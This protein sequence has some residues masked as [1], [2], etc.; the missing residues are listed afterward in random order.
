M[1]LWAGR[2]SKEVDEEVLEYTQTI[3]IDHKLIQSD[4]WCSLAHVIMLYHQN[5]LKKEE[6]VQ[7]LNCLKSLLNSAQNG[8]MDLEKK[9]ED[10][11]LNIEQKVIE[12]T[13]L[14]LGGRMHTARSRNDQVVTD[15]RIYLRNSI[16][17]VQERLISFINNL[18][19]T[20]NQH[21]ET[22]AVGYT[23]VQP[24]QPISFAFW[25]TAYASMFSRDL[26]RLSFTFENVNQNVLGSCALSGT[27]FPINRNITTKLLGFDRLLLHALDGT[28]SRDFIIQFLSDSSIIMSH[29][30]KLSEE[31]VLWNT[32]EF[33]LLD[34]DDAFATG[35]SIMPQK[36]NPVVAELAKGKTGRVYGALMQILTTVKGVTTGYNCDLQEDKPMLWDTIDQ[37][38]TTLSILEKH[39]LTS[40][41][42]TERAISMCCENFSTATELA[43]YLTES[44]NIPFRESHKITGDVVGK[45]IKEN[46]NLSYSK[47][48]CE[49]LDMYGIELSVQKA[50]EL[51]DPKQVIQRQTSQGATSK[52]SVEEII[53]DLENKTKYHNDLLI[54][55]RKKNN[56]AL[57]KTIQG[58]EEN[59]KNKDIVETIN[60]I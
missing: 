47:R 11:H 57:L 5:I 49:L 13:R 22:V 56:R 32:Y 16:L 35:S 23:H 28:S 12:A 29:L 41:Y 31:M 17:Q 21:K 7:I 59:N 25:L 37:V 9:Y 24:A 38:I 36:K 20:A 3:K 42:N 26:E 39:V 55:R 48:V 8:Q 2:F 4:I 10:V 33:G 6:S 60:N 1:K 34:I 52:Q 30:S 53:L 40:T 14:E 58:V 50:T 54:K 46:K 18:L 51:F 45:L 15:T 27:S 44:E 19:D 43:N